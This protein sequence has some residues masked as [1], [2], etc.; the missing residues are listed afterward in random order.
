[1]INKWLIRASMNI[2]HAILKTKLKKTSKSKTEKRTEYE[3][4]RILHWSTN[5][6]KNLLFC[7]KP[8]AKVFISLV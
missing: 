5:L 2:S 1:M 3:I 6:L 8:D 4:K 7:M